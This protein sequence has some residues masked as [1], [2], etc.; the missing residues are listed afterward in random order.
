M[1]I[2]AYII[3]IYGWLSCCVHMEPLATGSYFTHVSVRVR[4][5]GCVLLVCVHACVC[6]YVLVCVCVCVVIFASVYER[7]HACML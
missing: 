3:G 2:L 7:M 5:C 4:A 1:Y 6:V